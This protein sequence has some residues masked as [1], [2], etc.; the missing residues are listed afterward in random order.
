[1][2]FEKSEN[3]IYLSVTELSRYA[4]QRENLLMQKFGFV[5]ESSDHVSPEP[6]EREIRGETSLSPMEHG[7]ALHHVMETDSGLEGNSLTEAPLS[8]DLVCGAYHV[9]VQGY[10][11]IIAFDGVL[12][13]IEEIKTVRTLSRTLGP[14]TDP[15]HFAQAAVYA[16]L[17]AESAGLSEVGIRLTYQKRSDGERVSFFARFSRMAL[18]R[19]F[20]ALIDRATP[21]LMVY[22]ER[23]TVF[24]DEVTAMPFPYSSIREGQA[25]FIQSAY[26]AI[27]NGN[28][29]LV[30][31]PTGIGKTISAL[32]PAIKAV[33]EGKID[34]VFYFTAKNIT[35]MAAME[36]AK[37]ISRYAP[38]LRTVMICS[39]DVVCPIK[40]EMKGQPFV[41]NCRIC[42]RMDSLSE[43]FGVTYR[44]YRER[45][46]DAMT[47]LLESPD[48]VYTPERLIKTAD[49][50][51]ICPYELSLDLSE[52]CMV[53]VCDYNYVLDENVRFRRYFK[54]PENTEK[55]AFL[56]DE[57]HNLPDRVRDTYT[58]ELPFEFLP[59]LREVYETSFTAD[60][61]FGDRLTEFA[62]ALDEVR[63]LCDE[64]EYVRSTNEGDVTGAY[65]QANRVPDSLARTSANLARTLYSLMRED[66]DQAE[67][68]RPYYDA[69][70]GLV[71]SASFFDEKFRFFAHRENERVRCELLCLDPSGIIERMLAAGRSSI[72]FSATLSPMDYFHEVTGLRDAEVL[73]LDSPYERDNLCL[74]AFDSISTRY[75]DRK[76]TASDCADL[77]YEVTSVR[78]GNYIVYF[79]SY[80]YMKRV[81]RAFLNLSPDC[82]VVMQKT[83]M[84]RSERERFIRIFREQKQRSVVGFCVL[85][86]MFSEGIDLA[87][88]SLIGVIVF[89]TGMPQLSAERNL[90]SAYY[91]EKTERG[92][93]FAYVCPGMNKVQQAAGRVIRSE[94]DR[95][96]IVLAD[97]RLG[98]PRMRALFPKHWRHMKYTGD[99]E[100]LR[101][102]LEDFW[103]RMDG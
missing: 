75:S 36:A 30:S 35:G 73:E 64:S 85:G 69:L 59:N 44:A 24:A 13:T 23:F 97:D 102:I 14:F 47:E 57:A 5:R 84:S 56:F 12:H 60:P 53:V 17:F 65:G 8:R 72:L 31:A 77:I 100:S 82:A 62:R 66:D 86:G 63:A 95:G 79:P 93:D 2:R 91:D 18:E 10:A 67:V 54:N 68:L 34:K 29:L 27:K 22:A 50:Y 32:F 49:K 80:E 58:A 20:D 38:H 61:D 3:R 88:E 33:G 81:C 101:Y 89:G 4:F 40:K 55:Y 74:V 15:A 39:K 45:E 16:C 70:S 76:G 99:M 98:D 42:E 37:R 21:F 92:F 94:N 87:G 52:L 51:K 78:E 71:F 1:M 7:T 43:D 28:D 26:R 6:D 90:M 41:M 19:M 48:T 103:E 11:D 96:V 25:K 83:G 46:L 9:T